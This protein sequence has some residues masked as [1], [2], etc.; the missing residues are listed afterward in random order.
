MKSFEIIRILFNTLLL[1]H[2]FTLSSARMHP[3]SA[4]W[5]F[6]KWVDEKRLVKELVISPL[7]LHPAT[8][9]L[10]LGINEDR[11]I[12]KS[13]DDVGFYLYPDHR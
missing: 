8:T 11:I 7:N 9:G 2:F 5:N 10:P 6:H 3:S 1:V 4:K 12:S 13:T